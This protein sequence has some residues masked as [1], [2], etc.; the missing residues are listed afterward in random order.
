MRGLHSALV[1]A[2]ITTSFESQSLLCRCLQQLKDDAALRQKLGAAG[3][4]AVSKKTI[5]F[6]VADLLQWYQRG[7]ETAR[8]RSRQLFYRLLVPLLLGLLVPF[9]IGLFCFYNASVSAFS[10]DTRRCNS[11]SPPSLTAGGCA[12][13][14][15][16][17]R[18]VQGHC[19]CPKLAPAAERDQRQ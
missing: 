18:G 14:V 6:V 9:T 12:E 19:P 15:H 16:L 5:S 3:C 8:R 4:A 10:D 17:L 7:K 13:A 1:I 2:C 11:D